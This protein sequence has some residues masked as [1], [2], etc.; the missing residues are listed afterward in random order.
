MAACLQPQDRIFWHRLP[1][2][3]SRYCCA[4]ALP[5]VTGSGSGGTHTGIVGRLF[6]GW[7]AGAPLQVSGPAAGL[8]VIVYDLVQ[9]HELE[10]LVVAVL[11]GGILQLIAGLLRYGR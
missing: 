6:V 5:F 8:T 1:C 9:Q 7:L 11:V 4:W 10:V 3:S 2:S